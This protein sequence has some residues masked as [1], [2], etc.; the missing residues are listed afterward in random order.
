MASHVF[1]TIFVHVFAAFSL[2]FCPLILSLGWLL[3]VEWCFWIAVTL[4]S[5]SVSAL[6]MYR[7]QQ[8]NDSQLDAF[9][10]DSW[11]NRAV[12]HRGAAGDAPEN[13]LVA[14]RE[15]R[16]NGAT[17]VEFDVAL[18]KDKAPVIFHDDT[19][20]RTTDATGALKDLTLDEVLKLNAA[21]KDPLRDKFPHAS[22]PTLEEAT[23]ECLGLGMNIFFDVKDWSTE[24]VNA[25]TALFQRH[26]E[27]YQKGMVCSFFPMLSYKIRRQDPAILTALTTCTT[28]VQYG[29]GCDVTGPIWKRYP[30]IL[31][32]YL[33]VWCQSAWL[34]ILCGNAATL[35]DKKIVTEGTVDYWAQRGIKT[36]VWTVNDNTEKEYFHK[37]LKCGIITDNVKSS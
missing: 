31:A 18:T 4:L 2:V 8:P 6:W 13:T 33:L 36:V 20:D 29:F 37:C 25:L 15:A 10:G 23:V 1:L 5:A 30:C 28:T 17:F 35:L 21:A 3:P 34:W 19:V 9:F 11:P 14:F 26:T 16:K 12:C 24:M 22:I 7:L 32:D 27:L